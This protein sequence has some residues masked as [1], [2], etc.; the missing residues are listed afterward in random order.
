M[1]PKAEFCCD[2]KI[3]EDYYTNQVGHGLPYYSGTQYQRGYGLGS[4]F[5]SIGRAVLP[6]VKS[7]A[8]AVGKQV[9]RSGSQ[10]AG[11]LIAGKNAKQAAVRRAKQAGSRLLTRIAPPPPQPLSVPG[12]AFFPAPVKRRRKGGKASNA[13]RKRRKTVSSKADIFG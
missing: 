2:R 11:D 9:L 12:E 4:I 7:G 1:L 5:A 8:K 6:L 10:F 3:Y 13:K